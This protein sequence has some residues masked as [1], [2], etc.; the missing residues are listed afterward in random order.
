MIG[1]ATVRAADPP[2]PLRG[3]GEYWLPTRPFFNVFMARCG[4]VVGTPNCIDILEHG[5]TVIAFPEGC[6]A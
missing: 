2:R 1:T 3:M 5:E 4:G 6:A